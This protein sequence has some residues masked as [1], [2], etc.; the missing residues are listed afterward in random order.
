MPLAYEVREP[1]VIPDDA[2]NADGIATICVTGGRYGGH[3]MLHALPAGGEQKSK[4]VG[5]IF[6]EADPRPDMAV[7][8]AYVWVNDACVRAGVKLALVRNL[9]DQYGPDE[10]PYFAGGIFLIDRRES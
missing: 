6:T 9:N 10:A 7:D 3:W 2:Y 8:T 4:S 5:E 1:L